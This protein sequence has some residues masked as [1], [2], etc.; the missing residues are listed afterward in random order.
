M[1]FAPPPAGAFLI[2][3]KKLATIVAFRAGVL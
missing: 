2:D 1:I 3:E